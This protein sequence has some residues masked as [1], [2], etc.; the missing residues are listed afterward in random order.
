M[1]V[2]INKLTASYKGYGLW[3]DFW[4]TIDYIICEDLHQAEAWKD[5]HYPETDNDIYRMEVI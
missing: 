4:K 2:K 5:L 3:H 1:I